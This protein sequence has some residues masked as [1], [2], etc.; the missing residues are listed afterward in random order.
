MDRT[1]DQQPVTA[2]ALR[3]ACY[4]SA[5]PQQV[6]FLI[7]CEALAQFGFAGVFCQRSV[8]PNR[9]ERVAKPFMN[10]LVAFDGWE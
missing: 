3:G 7:A 1:L 9:L 8:Y 5:M 10:V 6:K 2:A 4:F